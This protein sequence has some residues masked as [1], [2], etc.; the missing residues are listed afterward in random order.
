[1]NSGEETITLRWSMDDESWSHWAQGRGKQTASSVVLEGLQTILEKQDALEKIRSCITDTVIPERESSGLP[2]Q[3]QPHTIEIQLPSSDFGEV[4]QR[5]GE[6]GNPVHPAHLLAAI[7]LKS[8]SWKQHGND[9]AEFD[10]GRNLDSLIYSIALSTELTHTKQISLG[11]QEK[12]MALI[13]TAA[14]VVSALAASAAAL[15]A[16]QALK[17]L[18]PQ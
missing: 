17:F 8:K 2:P 1:M 14:T 13:V 6:P 11:K 5:V 3:K 10:A 18:A 15:A 4:C 16:F 7:I 9:E 12:I